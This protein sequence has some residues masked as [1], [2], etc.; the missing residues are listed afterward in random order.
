L[1][2]VTLLMAAP[3]TGASCAEPVP[4]D[5]ALAEAETVFVGTVSELQHEGRLARFVVDEVW[6]G[7][8]PATV[9][10]S[11]GP[12]PSQLEG[13][14]P[15]ETIVTS[16]DRH[17]EVGM[18]YLVVPF[19]V[20]Q[21][22]YIDSGCSVTQVYDSSLAQYRPESAHPPVEAGIDDAVLTARVA[23]GVIAVVAAAALLIA[24]SRRGQAS[25][26]VVG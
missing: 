2:T 19:W 11:G 17:F 13:S 16:V 21:G 8:V 18:R 6:K 22:V 4:L 26:G 3:A 15:G 24:R 10:V 20:D 1:A 9:L 7:E 12:P 25:P 23:L 14:G 5:Q